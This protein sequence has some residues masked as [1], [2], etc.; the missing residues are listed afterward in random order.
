MCEAVCFPV[1]FIGEDGVAGKEPE[2]AFEDGCS[3][4]GA[5]QFQHAVVVLEQRQSDPQMACLPR[6]DGRLCGCGLGARSAAR[7]QRWRVRR[8][9]GLEE[10]RWSHRG[11]ALH[12]GGRGAPGTRRGRP[13]ASKKFFVKEHQASGNI[14]LLRP[15][16][17]L[18][19][20]DIVEPRGE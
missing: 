16:V 5:G 7:E 3:D 15:V 20:Y 6:V 17:Q 19:N 10:H 13:Q 11:P 14:G 9:T 1:V 4:V 12:G 8:S 2:G 18:R